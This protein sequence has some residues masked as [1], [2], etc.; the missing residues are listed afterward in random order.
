MRAI[1]CEPVSPFNN[2][3]I[4][5]LTG[6]QTLSSSARYI[7]RV[8]SSEADLDLTIS[9][10]RSHSVQNEGNFNIRIQSTGNAQVNLPPG[11]EIQVT[12]DQANNKHELQI[13]S[14]IT[15]DTAVSVSS[16][17]PIANNAITNYVNSLG[18]SGFTLVTNIAALRA[19]SSTPPLVV[20]K[21][22]GAAWDG[23]GGIFDLLAASGG[24]IGDIG[25]GGHDDNGAHIVCTS[26]GAVYGRRE[27][28]Y[29][30]QMFGVLAY[31]S[32]TA[33][34]A[35]VDQHTN[36]TRWVSFVTNPAG[37]SGWAYRTNT[38]QPVEGY[39]PDGFYRCHSPLE[40][41]LLAAAPYQSGGVAGRIIMAGRVWTPLSVETQGIIVNGGRRAG[42]P[43]MVLRACK[44]K[45]GDG[46]VAWNAKPWPDLWKDPA[47]YRAWAA[48]TTFYKE[49]E[50]TQVLG[51][52]AT[53]LY[54]VVSSGVSGG[55]APTD[56]TGSDFADGSAT[57]KYLGTIKNTSGQSCHDMLR[58]CRDFGIHIDY[59][60]DWHTLYCESEGY[61]VHLALFPNQ[62]SSSSI[63][64]SRF[65]GNGYGCKFGVACVSWLYDE[66]VANQAARLALTGLPVGYVVRQSD[67]ATNDHKF[68]GPLG[69]EATLGNW[70]VTTR[71]TADNYVNENFF[72]GGALYY[73]RGLGTFINNDRSVY[74]M[75]TTTFNT[76]GVPSHNLHEGLSVEQADL[77]FPAELVNVLIDRGTEHEIVVR[78]DHESYG[79]A[80]N[81]IRHL[82]GE[83]ERNLVKAARAGRFLT[84]PTWSRDESCGKQNRIE[85]TPGMHDATKTFE[86]DLMKDAIFS[87][88]DRIYFHRSSIQNITDV[89]FQNPWGFYRFGAS[90]YWLFNPLDRSFNTTVH[91]GPCV[92]ITLPDN[93]R[94]DAMIEAELFQTVNNPAT[95]TYH[96]AI[97]DPITG[98]WTDYSARARKPA[99]AN[100]SLS[101]TTTGGQVPRMG[102]P[103]L[104]VPARFWVEP[105]VRK[106]LVF[107]AGSNITG[108]RV[109]VTDCPGASIVSPAHQWNKIEAFV[110][111]KPARGIFRAPCRLRYAD[112]SGANKSIYLNKADSSIEYWA[113]SGATGGIGAPVLYQWGHDG[114][115]TVKEWDGSAWQTVIAGVSTLDPADWVEQTS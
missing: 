70:A 31:A 7:V 94:G 62:S 67:D 28:Q 105:W 37:F 48:T 112:Q 60:H 43:H 61:T 20:V 111:A 93:H 9:P 17:N 15:V 100:T 10:S 55:S 87:N 26:T 110:K 91:N 89:S 14:G 42:K 52:G 75:I 81:F 32:E 78:N 13:G 64:W 58:K 72:D 46:K 90:N 76:V 12:W 54:C 68:N 115:G 21:G 79:R 41:N 96:I 8:T 1:S 99:S 74:G 82:S 22:H 40:I 51:S 19:L 50:I 63:A 83:P 25:S 27:T 24:T 103:A 65:A 49:E 3:T 84:D 18:G 106:V 73:A 66:L 98:A 29:T 108:Y 36:M 5:S 57:L 56:V 11:G 102:T 4:L 114:A 101:W 16:P 107:V 92:V 39:V 23:G 97:G 80:A 109:R 59:C 104:A 86:V 30:P 34:A 33:A 6:N 35:G 113:T 47:V 69:G 77:V 44:Q 2:P 95:A 85:Q 71:N 45:Q 88:Y 38:Y 53:A